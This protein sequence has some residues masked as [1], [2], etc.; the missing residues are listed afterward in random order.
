VLEREVRNR[1]RKPAIAEAVNVFGR[2]RE[3]L[4]LVAGVQ[5]WAE[6]DRL[7]HEIAGG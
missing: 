5:R 1:G 4:S 3:L 6:T 2:G 7:Y